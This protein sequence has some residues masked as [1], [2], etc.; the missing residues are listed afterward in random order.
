M[1]YKRGDQIA[2]VP[3][4][5]EG[6]LQHPDVDFGF[7][8]SVPTATDLF[9]R[10]WSKFSPGEL[11]TKACSELTPGANVVHYDSVDQSLV[12]AE[13]K[14]LDPVET[15]SISF[16]RTRIHCRC[17]ADIELASSAIVDGATFECEDC[18]RVYT[19]RIGLEC[20]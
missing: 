7:V 16:L 15:A 18:D 3:T 14:K 10:Y 19:V 9:C 17:G 12:D 6:D 8:T 2:Y 4:H 5:A 13:I 20:R 1:G 11:R